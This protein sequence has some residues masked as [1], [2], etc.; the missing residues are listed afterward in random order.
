[1]GEQVT[2]ADFLTVLDVARILDRSEA[3][4][5]AYESAGKLKATRTKSGMRVFKM[6]DVLEFKRNMVPNSRPCSTD[7]QRLH[8]LEELENMGKEMTRTEHLAWAKQRALEY[9]D[10]GELQYALDSLIS[11][12]G[13]HPDTHDPYWAEA[14]VVQWMDG[15]LCTEETMRA[16]IN[17]LE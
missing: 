4:V 17:G 2:R 8:F 13:K 15:K 1:M 11:D 9:C 16:F 5:R 6:D 3:S 12:M 14:A 10:R 7:A